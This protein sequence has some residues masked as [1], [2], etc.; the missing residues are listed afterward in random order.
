MNEIERGMN[1]TKP[2]WQPPHTYALLFAMIVVTAV[3]TWVL[4]SGSFERENTV[5]SSGGAASTVIPGTFSTVDKVTADR[6]LRQ[7]VLDVLSAPMAGLVHAAD[8]I[9]FVLVLGG[10]F[11]IISRTGAIDRGLLALSQGLSGRGIYVIP[12]MLPLMSLGGSTFGMSEEIIALYPVVIALMFKLGFDS[13][14]A[15]LIL[16][17]GTQA[18]YIGATINPFSV[19][20]AQGIAS[21]EGNPQLGLRIFVWLAFTVL[22][23]AY[24]MWYAARV[25]RDPTL[26]PVFRSDRAL[27]RKFAGN[28][29]QTLEFSARDRAILATFVLALLLIAWGLITRGWYMAEI[30]AIF[31][32]SG[33]AAA[34]LARI[35]ANDAAEYFV[36]GCRDFIYAAFVI[37]LARG[38][39][40]VAEQ[41]MIIDPILHTLGQGLKDLPT[42]AFTSLT[43]VAHN[44]ITFLVPSSSG[45]AA[46]TMPV[47]APLADIFG[48]S[49]DSMVL[50]YQ[51]GNGLTNLISPT[52]G[53][54]LAG[55]S[56]AGINF[57]QWLRVILPFFIVGW[58]LA[59]IFLAISASL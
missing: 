45:E 57:A 44:L 38:I 12:V 29:E 48:V 52:N 55:L 50:S 30:S 11:G 18:G 46:L 31:L 20:L 40:V 51:M 32:A 49:R 28:P 56:I 34:A 22:A 26:S 43:L 6:D 24:T 23:V 9:A 41:G 21:I 1:D 15:V 17:L 10:A 53:I 33:L 59:A 19:L 58:L 14:T 8:V 47:F 4:P 37:G 35:T 25:R 39:L 13:I 54:L 2:R 42:F 27:R 7:G 36:D 3:L 16:F 5:T